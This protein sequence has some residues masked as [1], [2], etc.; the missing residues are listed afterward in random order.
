MSVFGGIP[1]LFRKGG[2]QIVL[3]IANCHLSGFELHRIGNLFAL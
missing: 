2:G 3:H 1:Y